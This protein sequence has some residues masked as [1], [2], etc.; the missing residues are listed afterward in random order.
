MKIAKIS[1]GML[2]IGVI[3]GGI[4]PRAEATVYT[5]DLDPPTTVGRWG[6]QGNWNPTTGPPG[7]DDTAVIPNGLTCYIQDDGS[8][9]AKIIN[10]QRGGVL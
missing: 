5:F 9:A 7:S 1:T 8:E 3:L 10:V 2:A 4:L 6:V